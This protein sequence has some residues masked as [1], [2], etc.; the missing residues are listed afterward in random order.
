MS[1]FSQ[2]E[3]YLN[4]HNL[5][6]RHQSAYRKHHSTETLLARVVSDL[7]SD[8]SNGKH[9]LLAM[10]DLSAA[11]DTVDHTILIQ[12][13]SVTFGIKD[14]ALQWFSS[15]LSERS[16]SVHFA[17]NTSPSTPVVCGVPQ[18]SVLGPLL[19]L[20]YTSDIGSIA[21]KHHINSHSFADDTQ[22]YLSGDPK[23]TQLLRTS[24]VAC[25]NEITEWCAANKLK[26]NPS[27]TEFLWSATA[28]RQ[29]QLDQTPINFSDGN[30]RPS[31]AV[32][33]LGVMIDSQLSFA[34][35]VNNI[36][37]KCYAELRRIKSF[38]RSLPTDAARTLVNSL[39]VSKID[40]C[41]SLLAG[42]PA[43]LTDKLQSVL[44]AAAR[45]VCGLK[46][47][48]HI[49]CHMRDS[50]HWLRFPQRVTFKLC[51][52]TYKSLNGCAP[53]Y[54]TELCNPVS[55]SEPR[56]RL[57]SAAVGDLIIP[58]TTTSFGDRAFAHAAP[59]AWNSLPSYIRAAKTLPAF[60][61]LL[62]THLFEQCYRQS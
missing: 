55:R 47:Y 33:D 28:R 31:K 12:R 43:N 7:I 62:K 24:I 22:L 59:H 45:I 16:Q 41:N 3:H 53:D 48:D 5:L 58:R 26:L 4:A 56:C 10:L 60:K 18:G 49:T 29:S 32:R 15:Y 54:L 6:P 19:F 20:L 46:K 1:F 35:H 9:T 11:F 38:R 40:Y 52:L 2:I 21:S 51:L 27:K 37:C 30:I 44:N 57:R 61:K 34:Q 14:T 36:S 50:L 25:I 8:A 23:D 42:A 17:R 13:L 39:V